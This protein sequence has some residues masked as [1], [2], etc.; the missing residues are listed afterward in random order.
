MWHSSCTS[1]LCKQVR[2]KL[3]SELLRVHW[4][5]VKR[6]ATTYFAI[7]PWVVQKHGNIISLYIDGNLSNLPLIFGSL[8]S[9]DMTWSFVCVV[10]IPQWDLTLLENMT[11]T[12]YCRIPLGKQCADTMFARIITP[13]SSLM[14]QSRQLRLHVQR[15]L[16]VFSVYFAVFRI[17]LGFSDS[18]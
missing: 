6:L 1:L 3:T 12:V 14:G 16:W 18:D 4:S 8:T 17:I 15:T 13:Q 2:L 11:L 9:W 5:H 7:I 10:L